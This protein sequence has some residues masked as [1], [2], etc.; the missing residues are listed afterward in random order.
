MTALETDLEQLAMEFWEWRDATSFRTSDDIPR[1]ERPAGWVPR[2][3]PAAIDEFMLVLGGFADRWRSLDA[4]GLGVLPVAAQVDHRL[5]SAALARA[6]WELAV[7]RNWERDAVFLTSQIL[8]PWFDLLLAP[9]PFEARR[10]SDLVRVLE[11]IPAAVDQAIAN[12]ERAG[13]AT[14]ARVAAAELDDIEARLARSV[15]EVSALLHRTTAR[16]LAEAQPGAG[17]ALERYR[18]WLEASADRLEP[19]VIVGRDA[20]VWYL[21]HVALVTAEPEELVR[22]AMQDYRRSV[23]AETVT[24]NRYRELPEAPLAV[25]AA[26][27]VADQAAGEAEVRAFYEDSELLSQP[28]TLRRYLF[29]ATPSYLEPIAFLGVNDDLTSIRRHGD[30]ATSYVPAPASDLPYFDAANAQDPRLGIIHEG[31]HSQQLALSWMQPNP[32]RRHFID[33]VANEGIAHYNEELMLTAGLFAD[34]PHSQT[35][36][37]NFMRLRAL[38]VV[39]DV[40]LATG[41]FSLQEAVDF[42]VRLVPMDVETATTETSYYVATPGLAMAYHVGKV[43]VQRILTDAAVA[44]QLNDRSFSLRDFHD[45]VWRNGNVP[46]SLQRWELLGDR[47]DVDLLDAAG[48]WYEGQP[49]SN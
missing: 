5:L 20:F 12:L 46:M 4:K 48:P 2:F 15:A 39:V 32:A 21:R 24:R 26:A 47:G 31:A 7:L 34:A 25:D 44:A 29:A 13:V 10:Q 23:V 42:F 45:F 3:D 38:R 27:E 17:A 9:P 35:I 36:V 1:V 11:A 30:D 14:L 28:T 19:D 16:S 41:A 6:H 49:E 8:G 18:G 37:H 33:S 43:E 22:A 40:N